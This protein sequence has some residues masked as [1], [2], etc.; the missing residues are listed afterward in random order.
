[1]T[2]EE[3][4]LNILES[5]EARQK[6]QSQIIAT[7][8]CPIISLTVNSPG[9]IKNNDCIKEV[10]MIGFS[11][12]IKAAVIDNLPILYSTLDTTKDTGPEAIIA[13]QCAASVIK[14]KCLELEQNHPLGRLWDADVI[15]E[16]S[17][18]VNRQSLGFPPRKCFICD[19]PAKMCARNQSHSYKELTEK[20]HEIYKQYKH[21][22]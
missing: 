16:S 3:T 19:E 9:A 10:F 2:T 8:G 13:I 21:L 22:R 15:S 4:H 20:F 6:K 17:R 14:V 12:L 7:Y 18:A 1:M 5:R 11:N